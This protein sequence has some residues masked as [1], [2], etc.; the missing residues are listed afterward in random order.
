MLYITKSIELDIEHCNFTGNHC[1]GSEGGGAL[2][3]RTSN[4]CFVLSCNFFDN[5]ASTSQISQGGAV[6]LSFTSETTVL[7]L[8]LCTFVNNSCPFP[9]SHGH[10]VYSTLLYGSC[11]I[12]FSNF[13]DNGIDVEEMNSIIYTKSKLYL[14]DSHL[15]YTDKEKASSRAIYI[16]S[17]SDL[18]I[19]G[20][21]IANFY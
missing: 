13:T 10:V 21:T 5:H 15:C 18:T 19:R 11:S 14:Y 8:D 1:D 3:I 12:G 9:D 7:T 4:D 16:G 17:S 20:S 6:Y 2:W